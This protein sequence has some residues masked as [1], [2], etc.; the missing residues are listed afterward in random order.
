MREGLQRKSFLVADH[1]RRDSKP[2][3]IVV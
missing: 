2:K 1:A 3:K